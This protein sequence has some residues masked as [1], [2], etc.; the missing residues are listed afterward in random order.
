MLYNFLKTMFGMTILNYS[1]VLLSMFLFNGINTDIN[2]L[3]WT[4]FYKNLF[5]SL[6]FIVFLI[7]FLV[8]FLLRSCP[9]SCRDKEEEI[10]Q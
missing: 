5:L 3:L 2:I 8:S 1:F 9:R 7:S 10:T 4:D 6:M